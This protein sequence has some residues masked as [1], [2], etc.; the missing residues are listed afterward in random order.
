MTCQQVGFVHGDCLVEIDAQHADPDPHGY[1]AVLSL[2]EE[3]GAIVR[4]L[5]R[6]N[7]RRIKIHAPSE[8]L[9]LNSAISYL[10]RRFGAVR[11]PE[12]GC[13]LAT[14][15]FGPPVVVAD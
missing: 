4:P 15:S 5:V 11:I 7:G 8:P 1:T 9:A 3:G 14:S 13:A 2:L 6:L 10:E 12:H